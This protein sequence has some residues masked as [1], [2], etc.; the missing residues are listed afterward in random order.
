MPRGL[1][2]LGLAL[3]CGA[4]TALCLPRPGLCF[5]AWFSLAPLFFL[6][7]KPCAGLRA[8]LIGFLAGFGFHGTALY[9]I[10]DT[11]RFAGLHPIVALLAW[12][13]LT[14]VLA[15][16]WAIIGWLGSRLT[17][18]APQA[19]RP[20]LWALAWT[21][22]TV[23]TE[24]WTPRLGVDL[25][26]YT[27][28]RHLS[29]LQLSAWAGPHALGFLIVLVNASLRGGRNL[30]LALSLVIL[31]WGQGAFELSRRSL[32]A[33]A[34]GVEILQPVVDQYQK[35][36]PSFARRITDNFKELLSRPRS[37][38]PALIVWPESALPHYVE[39]E[40]DLSVPASWS[41][42]LGAH[43]VVGALSRDA[44]GFHNSA[45]LILPGGRAGSVY[46]KRRLVPFGEFVPLPFL[47]RFIGLLSQMGGIS[48]GAA[49]QPLFQTPLGPAAAGI[50]YEAIFPALAR[51]D[52]RRG[53]RLLLNLTNDGW[54]KE[55]WG[56]HQHFLA[57]I[58]RAVENRVTVIRAGNTGI[59]GVIDP[60]GVV[61]A[62]LDLGQRGRLDASVPAQD[63]FPRRSFYTR[64]GDWFGLLCVLL[65]S[66]YALYL[67]FRLRR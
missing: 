53:A 3:F 33:Q 62:R 34:K 9:W 10:Y 35:W 47:E 40:K 60:W 5:L 15:V 22:V 43:Q 29:L 8:S 67:L 55:T 18:A 21:A 27:Q 16:N 12:S 31:A 32:G 45:F 38:P 39:K 56:P 65:T 63:P 4:A 7:R 52:A 2:S 49:E 61:T 59:S 50:C 66:S 42:S 24:R 11:C 48:P 1:K 58:Y 57:N 41:R 46:H 13:A 28:W 6:W 30:A 19:L 36:D 17:L 54:Y 51:G 23:I 26:A 64:H 37:G 44:G 20:W 25:L 14:A